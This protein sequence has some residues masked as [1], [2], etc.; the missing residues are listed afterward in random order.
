MNIIVDYK[1]GL[2]G[3]KFNTS[4]LLYQHSLTHTTTAYRTWIII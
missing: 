1:C 3:D 4:E 2:C